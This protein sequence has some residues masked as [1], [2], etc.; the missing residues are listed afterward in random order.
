MTCQNSGIVEKGNKSLHL[1]FHIADEELV[2]S[3]G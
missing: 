1:Y 2:I 3:F